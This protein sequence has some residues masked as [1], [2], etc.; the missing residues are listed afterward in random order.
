MGITHLPPHL[1]QAAVIETHRHSQKTVGKLP[2]KDFI[3]PYQRVYRKPGM[4]IREGG[5][6][7]WRDKRVSDYG[8]AVHHRLRKEKE[9]DAVLGVLWDVWS[10]GNTDLVHEL[11]QTIDPELVRRIGRCPRLVKG[12]LAGVNWT[13]INLPPGEI[14]V[15]DGVP[16]VEMLGV[17][18]PGVW[19]GPNL[20]YVVA[21]FHVVGS[22]PVLGPWGNIVFTLDPD[23]R[24]TSWGGVWAIHEHVTRSFPMDSELLVALY[25]NE[26]LMPEL[27]ITPKALEVAPLVPLPPSVI[28]P[29]EVMGE[30][31]RRVVGGQFEWGWTF[32]TIGGKKDNPRSSGVFKMNEMIGSDTIP[33]LIG[34]FWEK[35]LL[36]PHHNILHDGE[37]IR[38]FRMESV[39]HY[40]WGP[41]KTP[42]SH[43]L[44]VPQLLSRRLHQRGAHVRLEQVSPFLLDGQMRPVENRIDHR[45]SSSAVLRRM[46]ERSH[47]YDR[48]LV[49]LAI[50]VDEGGNWLTEEGK[51]QW[52]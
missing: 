44:L 49:P 13:G 28:E 12:W 36:F 52:E 34:G 25:A 38:G 50:P 21:G 43:R 24:A 14:G 37:F 3:Q 6:Q 30:S 32:G 11:C 10:E 17:R 26:A 27:K 18:H 23:T 20:G 15:I 40:G 48:H 22:Q 7:E 19:S 42:P 2:A 39:P 31:R 35:V 47:L 16:G 1:I 4:L 45:N 41:P 46:S 9:A 5:I 29:E 8:W 33:T 51:R